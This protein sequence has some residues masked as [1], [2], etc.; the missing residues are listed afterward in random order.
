M[1]MTSQ[2]FKARKRFG[3]HFLIKENVIDSIVSTVLLDTAGGVLEIGPGLGA[4][5]LPIAKKYNHLVAVE[6]D[7]DA[8]H[9]LLKKIHESGLTHDITLIEK[10]ILSCSIEELFGGKKICVVG[11]LPYNISKAI[12]LK[13]INEQKFISRAVLMFQ[14]EVAERLLARPGTSHYG[15]L[16]VIIQYYATVHRVIDVPKSCFRP[17]PKVDS[18]VVEIDFEKPYPQKISDEKLFRY[19]VRAAFSHRRKTL[20]NSLRLEIKSMNEAIL[21]DIFLKCSID[22]V[23][24]AETL[25]INEFLLLT[26]AFQKNEV[27]YED[28]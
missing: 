4:I 21:N 28:N 5:T 22:P 23:R 19:I 17:I 27:L 8:L 13:I 14:N 15:S 1:I 3:Q 20:F 16:S 9:I 26:E 11:N 10:D 6:K 18:M 7:R 25:S 2:R 12:L 24:R